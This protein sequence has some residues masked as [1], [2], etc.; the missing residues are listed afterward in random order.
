MPT[1]DKRQPAGLEPCGM[2]K[3]ERGAGLGGGGAGTMWDVEGRAVAELV[4][5]RDP[6]TV[7]A[8]Q[9]I[10]SWRKATE[11][12]IGSWLKEMRA[13]KIDGAE[14]IAAANTLMAK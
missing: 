10:V 7:L 12:V 1:R 3:R 14:L 8:A 4:G 5:G 6:I 9:D 11:P 2:W 13:R